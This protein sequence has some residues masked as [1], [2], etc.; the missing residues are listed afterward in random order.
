MWQLVTRRLVVMSASAIGLLSAARS[1]VAFAQSGSSTVSK[2]SERSTSARPITHEWYDAFQ[3]VEFD[4]WDALIADDV[5]INSPSGRDIRGL[6]I[7]KQFAVQFTDLGY[8]IDLLDEHLALNPQ[9]DG[10]GF[11]TILLN[12]KHN[13]KFGDLV[14]TGREGTS[15]ETLIFTIRNAKIARIDIADNTLDLALYKWERGW[16]APQNVRP[17]AII[18]GIDRRGKG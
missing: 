14:P 15:V 8:R 13:K 16:P 3:R 11:V 5:L 1:S 12:W 4:R 18:V 6:K 17:E 10:R 9:G 7:F 2:E